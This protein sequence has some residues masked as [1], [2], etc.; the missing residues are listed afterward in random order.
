MVDKLLSTVKK[1]YKPGGSPK[2]DG[3]H[4]P[5]GAGNFDNMDDYNIVDSVNT[6]TGTVRHTPTNPFDIVN[7]A[8]AD[9]LGGGGLTVVVSDP[10]TSTDGTMILNTTDNKIKVWYDSRWQ[11]LHTLA[12]IAFLVQENGD[13]IF[14]ENGDKLIT[15]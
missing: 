12:I 4:R 1:M 10:A 15:E 14:Q 7:K 13:L 3:M 8:Y 6:N 2:K 9:S 11:V 5:E